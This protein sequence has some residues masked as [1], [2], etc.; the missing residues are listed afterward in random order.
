MFRLKSTH[1]KRKVT[2]IYLCHTS[3]IL[4]DTTKH[5]A[6]LNVKKNEV[7]TYKKKGKN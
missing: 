1:K 5:Y 2:V 7:A 3:Y 6:L 4:L